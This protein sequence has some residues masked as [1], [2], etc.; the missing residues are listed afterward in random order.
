MMSVSTPLLE[1][2]AARGV[3]EGGTRHLE[4]RVRT[5]T[6]NRGALT[7]AP[8]QYTMGSQLLIRDNLPLD[9]EDSDDFLLIGSL[10]LRHLY[11]EI[12]VAS[13]TVLLGRS[14]DLPPS[15]GMREDVATPPPITARPVPSRAA[16]AGT[17]A[18]QAKKS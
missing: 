18:F 13:Q 15:A 9:A 11:L 12:D 4:V 14:L 16:R 7:Y 17:R 10:F 5:S 3:A 1:E 2:L 6:G 8:G